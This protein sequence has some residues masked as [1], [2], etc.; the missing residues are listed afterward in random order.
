MDANELTKTIGRLRRAQ[1]MNPDT[2]E[3][4]TALEQLLRVQQVTLHKMT[5]KKPEQDEPASGGKFDRNAYQRELMRKR[6]AAAK[7]G[8]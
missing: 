8:K 1:P 2:N 6:R 4:C 7:G 5:E 3:V